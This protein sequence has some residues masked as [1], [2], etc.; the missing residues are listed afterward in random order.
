MSDN[1]L[2]PPNTPMGMGREVLLQG[3]NW[4]SCNSKKKWFNVLNDEVQLIKDAG[5]TAVWMPPPTK[6][7]SDQGY[8]PSDLYNLTS[9]YGNHDELTRCIRS[10]KDAGLC[11]VA[12]IVI[13]HRRGHTSGQTHSLIHSLMTSWLITA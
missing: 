13:N 2:P 6:S 7:V 11:P 8:L 5:F 1:P 10:M 3:F 4:E 12:D 9:F